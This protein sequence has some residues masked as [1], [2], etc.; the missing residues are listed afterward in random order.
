MSRRRIVLLAIVAIAFAVLF[1]RL[2]FWQ[3]DR[4]AQ[5]IASNEA[6]E[7][8]LAEPVVPLIVGAG[9]PDDTTG[10]PWRRARVIGRWDLTSEVILRSRSLDGRPGV[11]LL[12][13]LR[14]PDGSTAVMVLRGWLPAADGLRPD[15]AAGRPRPPRDTARV[16]VEG[17][18]LPSRDGRGGE[19]IEVE[20]GGRRY[21][22]L[23]ARDLPRVRERV[24]FE[25]WP[26][27]LRADDDDPARG[28]PGP[29]RDLVAGSG[30]HLSYAI[31]WFSFAAIT[32]VGTAIVIGK[33][34]RA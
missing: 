11:E 5:R 33:E 4:R 34:R 30:P 24:D 3:L 25:V 26:L 21:V 22:A 19:P 8:R 16:E 10:L 18:L 14:S 27:V 15:L 31:Q 6:R 23:A 12:T 28:D 1:T 29:A 7:A 32:L 13:P 17:V 9:L 2:G 20:L